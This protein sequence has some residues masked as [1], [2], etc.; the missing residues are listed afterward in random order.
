MARRVSKVDKSAPIRSAPA[1]S[2]EAEENEMVALA[3]A[4]AKKQLMEGTASSQIIVHYLKLG[5]T[6]EM[7][8][9]EKAKREL[10]LLEA[11]TEAIKAAERVEGLYADALAAFRKC[12]YDTEYSSEEASD[13]NI[14]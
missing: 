8:E 5:S 7:I 12:S 1:L 3:V 13:E 10:E 6:T 2:P 4:A 9:R 14:F 11:K